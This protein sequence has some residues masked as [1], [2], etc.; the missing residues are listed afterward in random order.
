MER[1]AGRRALGAEDHTQSASPGREDARRR[2]RVA[3][4][5]LMALGRPH[6]VA[7]AADRLA[8]SRYATQSEQMADGLDKATA[9]ALAVVSLAGFA[10]QQAIRILEP[11]VISIYNAVYEVYVGK[12][13]EN[14]LE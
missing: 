7:P 4:M 2:V 8:D 1:G 12:K 9:Q 3:L 11:L 6:I 5:S 14:L 13:S 10:I